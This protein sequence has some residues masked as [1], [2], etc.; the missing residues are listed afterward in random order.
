MEARVKEKNSS[1]TISRTIGKTAT[2]TLQKQPRLLSLDNC[3]AKDP[4]KEVGFWKKVNIIT[5]NLKTKKDSFTVG[6]ISKCMES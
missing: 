6:S 3:Y 2:H 4:G 1:R 5:E